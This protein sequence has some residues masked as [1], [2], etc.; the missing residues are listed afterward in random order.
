MKI[1]ILNAKYSPNLGDGVIAECLEDQIR[2]AIPHSSVLSL[3]IGGSV[4]YRGNNTMLPRNLTKKIS[5]IPD[6]L[7]RLGKFFI[8]PILLRKKY[9]SKWQNYLKDSDAL[10]IGGGQLF[11]DVHLYFPTR[12]MIATLAAPLGVPILVH[13]VGVSQSLTKIGK[14]YFQRCFSHG[15]LI[16]V[17]VRDLKSKNNWEKHFPRVHTEI[18]WDPALLAY[19]TYMDTPKKSINKIAN[20]LHIGLGICDPKNMKSHADSAIEIAGGNI[21]F[22]LKTIDILNQN[23]YYVSLFTNGDDQD[24]LDKLIINLK[25]DNKLHC[26]NILPRALKP[27]QL[28]EQIKQFD[29]LIA[30]RLHANIIAYSFSIPSIGLMWDKKMESFFKLTHREEFLFTQDNP[31]L[32]LEKVKSLEL[33]GIDQIMH[34]KILLEAQEASNRMIHK[35]KDISHVN[36]KYS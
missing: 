1:V 4:D 6:P 12:I 36:K 16:Y 32:L 28:V 13:A 7:Q 14:K 19:K 23:N 10:V 18:A 27:Y 21:D 15:Q 24:F 33:V 9:Y 35:L 31:Q 11:M 30:H 3:D 29:M 2:T 26:V 25:S 20:K 17:S 5:Y 22:F 8:R 34:S